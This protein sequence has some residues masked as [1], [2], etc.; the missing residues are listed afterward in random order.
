MVLNH[1]R[2]AESGSHGALLGQ[3]GLYASM[4]QQQQAAASG[5]MTAGLN[6]PDGLRIGAHDRR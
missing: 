3:G 6:D 5:D 1:G 4:W 2:V